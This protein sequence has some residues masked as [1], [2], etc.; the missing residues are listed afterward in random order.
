MIVYNKD[1]VTGIRICVRDW[2]EYIR[3]EF[4]TDCK[5]EP[6]VLDIDVDFYILKGEGEM[7]LNAKTVKVKQDDLVSVEAGTSRGI[8]TND[9]EMNILVIKHLSHKKWN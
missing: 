2:I 8:I 6:H 3:L 5:I 1:G 7:I 4:G 9:K